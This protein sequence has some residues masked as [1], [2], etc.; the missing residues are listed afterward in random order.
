[1]IKILMFGVTNVNGGIENFALNYAKH[2][3]NEKI[4]IDIVDIYNG[5]TYEKEFVRH[6]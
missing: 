5:I 2:I 4:R 6:F 1:M 3:N